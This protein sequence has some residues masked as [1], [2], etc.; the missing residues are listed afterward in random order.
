MALTK[1]DFIKEIEGMSVL[2]LNDLVEALKEKFN[3][4][5]AP[6]AVAGGG[7][8]AGAAEEKSAFNVV[9]K[10]IGS[11]K[12]AV[13]KEVKAILGVGLKE[14]KEFTEAVGKPLKENVDKAGA[15][16]MKK[17]LEGAG[18]LVELQ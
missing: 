5:G 3:V 18:A 7:D 6:V 16:E 8:S 14:A 9:I 11:N 17:K 2:E 10:E 13:I 4:S 15:E 12:I 1:E